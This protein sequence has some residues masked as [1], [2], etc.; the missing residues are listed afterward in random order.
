MREMKIRGIFFVFGK[1][2]WRYIGH[3]MSGEV[4]Q[5]VR[6]PAVAGLFYPDRADECRAA[7]RRLL[8]TG[9]TEAAKAAADFSSQAVGAI[10]PHA[11]W[12][13]SGEIAAEAI[14]AAAG[15]CA[16]PDL[17][18]VFGAIHTPIP[19]VASA[20]DS[21]GRWSMP[22]EMFSVTAELRERLRADR[23]L[24]VVDDRFHLRE[25][26]V[27]V[28]LPLI[29]LAWPDAQILPIE[30][31]PNEGAAESGRTVAR[32]V[33][34]MGLKAVYLASSDLTHYGPNYRFT[35]KGVGMQALDWAMDNDQRLLD[36]V[37][38]ME[39]EG[40]V[41]EAAANLNACGPGAIAAMMAACQIAGAS[42]AS[43]LKHT[44]SYQTL[45]AVAPQA[46]D[47]AV[48]YAAVMLG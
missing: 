42:R 7:A 24:F 20:L 39:P 37:C 35:P 18:V 8:E 25:H 40:V 30:T 12:V 6:Y 32:R 23:G 19:I 41:Q 16:S 28:E 34:E 47:N 48:G 1:E 38:A 15:R 31:P 14:A 2:T 29:R 27:E 3:L 33:A 10:V 5:S 26:A 45:A 43:V 13:C 17:V 22:G 11:G 36:A 9:K 46:P 21:Y 44:N 4:A